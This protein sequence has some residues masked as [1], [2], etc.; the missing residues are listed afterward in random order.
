MGFRLEWNADEAREKLCSISVKNTDLKNSCPEVITCP[1]S[2]QLKYAPVDGS[3]HNLRNPDW[4]KSKGIWEARKASDGSNLQSPRRISRQ[5]IQVDGPDDI[6]YTLM[7]MTWG[8]FITHDLTQ[9]S[10]YTT[11]TNF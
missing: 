3:C 11:G 6:D 9:A 1:D 4:G 2:S 5:F 10:S 8:Q 7:L